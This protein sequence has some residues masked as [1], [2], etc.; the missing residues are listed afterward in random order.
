MTPN[1]LI[2]ALLLFVSLIV[3][4]V[5]CYKRFS[6]IALGQGENRTDNIPAR[7]QQL[8]DH[9]F[10]QQRVI[11]K[12]SGLNH[13]IIFWSFIVLLLANGEFLLKGLMPSLSLALLPQTAYSALLFAFDLV[14]LLTLAA[15]FFAAAR[16][17]FFPPESLS[18]TYVKARS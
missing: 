8:F 17:L 10:A 12:P 6:L 9:A 15:V 7:L 18:S 16:R 13:A 14:A 4:C 5:G 3:F 2:F 11:A 1:P